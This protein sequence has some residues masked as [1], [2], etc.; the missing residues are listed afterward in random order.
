MQVFIIRLLEHNPKYIILIKR[1]HVPDEDCTMAG[2]FEFA[3]ISYTL[4]KLCI[5][6]P[7]SIKLSSA[8]GKP[9]IRL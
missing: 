3:L 5:V 9:E 7:L 6:L 1:L 4:G 8:C 2:Q